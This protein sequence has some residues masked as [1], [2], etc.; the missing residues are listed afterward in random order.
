ML[1]GP[2]VVVLAANSAAIAAVSVV[3]LVI[4]YGLLA[5]L[6]Y[7]VFSPGAERRAARRRQ[8]R[9]APERPEPQPASRRLPIRRR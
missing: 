2:A 8:E 5:G 1:P 4:G 3:S 7:F 6:W 9:E